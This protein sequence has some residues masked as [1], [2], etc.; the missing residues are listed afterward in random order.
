[1][2][3]LIFLCL[4]ALLAACA[5]P[6]P[7]PEG[8][9]GDG[10]NVVLIT[11]DG[12]RWQEV[13]RGADPDLIANGGYVNNPEQLRADFWHDDVESRR[14]LLMP[15]LWQRIGSDGQL[16]GNREYGC[17]AR[18]SN[19]MWFS[20]PGYNEMLVGYPDDQRITSNDPIDNPNVTVLEKI[21]QLPEF[22][23]RVAG[24]AM[25]DPVG[26]AVNETRSGIPMRTSVES[27]GSY[28]GATFPAF[29][30]EVGGVFSTTPWHHTRDSFLDHVTFNNTMD[31]VEEMKPRVLYMALGSPDEDAHHGYYEGY[32]Q[33][34]RRTDEYIR[35]LWEALESM[36]EYAGR[37]SYL[38]TVDHGRGLGEQWTDHGSKTPHSD[39]VW[40]ALLGPGITARG[41]VTE[42]CQLST[43]QVASTVASLL[44]VEYSNERAVAPPLP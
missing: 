18:L 33:S 40:F 9:R 39:E 19:G 41:E 21:H 13:F 26:N 10:P 22:R 42:P 34:I 44:G 15:F 24:A 11:I 20:Y 8:E 35:R 29:F 32:L 7:Q 36:P 17:E 31:L 37:T 16:Y 23:G 1:M 5:S 43:A 25:W 3:K 6:V 30:A 14:E 27:L 38:I 28:P 4:V 12:L 2:Y